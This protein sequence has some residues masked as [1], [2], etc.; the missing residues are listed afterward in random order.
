MSVLRKPCI[1]ERSGNR[2]GVLFPQSRTAFGEF[3]LQVL[4]NKASDF[5]QLHFRLVRT[6]LESGS[7]YCPLFI[8]STGNSMKDKV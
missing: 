5:R 6:T 7:G 1:S 4:Y 2:I 3:S 8:P